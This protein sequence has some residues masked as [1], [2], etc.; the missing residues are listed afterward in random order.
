MPG[1]G[2][3]TTRRLGRIAIDLKENG[4]GGT[5]LRVYLPTEVFP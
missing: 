2:P 3:R 1:G 4:C 5:A